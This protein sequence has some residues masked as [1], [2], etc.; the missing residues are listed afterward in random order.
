M[1]F[2]IVLALF[3]TVFQASISM[4]VSILCGIILVHLYRVSGLSTQLFFMT[5]VSF[6]A[7]A[8]SQLVAL[9][10]KKL[11][12]AQGL[13]GIIGA[14]VCM[15]APLAFFVLLHCYCSNMGDQVAVARQL[16]ASFY[17][18]YYDVIIAQCMPTIVGVAQLIFVLCFCSVTV[19]QLLA[20]GVHELTP[21]ALTA[22]W[23]NE[24]NMLGVLLMYIARTIIVLLI[25]WYQPPRSVFY[26][27]GLVSS[28]NINLPALKK[29][30]VL[31]TVFCIV[32]LYKFYGSD[33]A[34]KLFSFGTMVFTGSVSELLGVPLYKPIIN[35]FFIATVSACGAVIVAVMV[36]IAHKR[37]NNRALIVALN[38][39]IFIVGGVGVGVLFASMT[40]LTNLP[41]GLPV[42]FSHVILNYPFVTRIVQP[43]ITTFPR[44][45]TLTAQS[46]GATML[47]CVRTLYVPHARAAVLCGYAV[48]FGL[49]LA[50]VGAQQIIAGNSF[51]TIPVAIKLF[52]LHEAWLE[53]TGMSL[54]LL[55]M[56]GVMFCIVAV[57]M[58]QYFYKKKARNRGSAL[59]LLL[60]VC[61][62][63]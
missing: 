22:T 30:I 53:I 5:V 44:E 38:G 56:T 51:M 46:Y 41:P 58:S 16:G 48:A 55:L 3:Y 10:V 59:A 52:R 34:D 15:N 42:V 57:W 62:F 50:E 61:R 45:F 12:Q 14:H 49:S 40:R 60:F 17:R 6:F 32:G 21:D 7:V 1:E 33:A 4:V 39:G 36:S 47:Q 19:P 20:T 28:V 24:G 37:I 9:G 8:P 2:S 26:R 23:F 43:V 25:Y 18:A 27:S 54:V 31:L 11:L 29:K 63:N 35:S 13:V